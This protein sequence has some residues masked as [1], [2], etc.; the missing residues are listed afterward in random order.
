MIEFWSL[1]STNIS[2]DRAVI[3]RQSKTLEKGLKIKY[4]YTRASNILKDNILEK[5][6]KYPILA[7]SFGVGTLEKQKFY[8]FFG[9]YKY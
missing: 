5:K 2:G 7:L 4:F 9:E 8:L 6:T 1:S 3:H